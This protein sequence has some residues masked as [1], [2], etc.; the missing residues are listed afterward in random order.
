MWWFGDP[1]SAPA[2]SEKNKGGWKTQERG[3]HTIKTLPK[4]GFGPP[5]LWYVFPPVCFRPVVFLRR[6][7]R[8]RPG[9]SHFLRPPKLVLECAL[10][11]TFS[12]AKIARYVFPPPLAAFQPKGNNHNSNRHLMQHLYFGHVVALLSATVAKAPYWAGSSDIFYFCPSSKGRGWG[13]GGFRGE[14]EFL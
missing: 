1:Q 5:H 4:N 3:K 7:N 2:Q 6:R 11:G 13:G 9:K 10:Y 12:P 14:G 8:H